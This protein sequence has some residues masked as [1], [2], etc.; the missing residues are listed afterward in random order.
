LELTK[1]VSD[2][3][4]TLEEERKEIQ[5]KTKDLIKSETVTKELPAKKEEVENK[6]DEERKCWSR[7]CA[8]KITITCRRGG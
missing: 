6:F 7:R 1:K 3:Q 5:K 4:K 2:L 8:N